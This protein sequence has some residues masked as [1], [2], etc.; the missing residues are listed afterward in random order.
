MRWQ[1]FGFQHSSDFLYSCATVT[2]VSSCKRDVISLLL[3]SLKFFAELYML[4]RLAFTNHLV[5]LVVISLIKFS[6][7]MS[8][9]DYIRVNLIGV[10]DW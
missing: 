9:N 5:T 1:N 6:F 4:A 7:K 2:L 3:I 10:L 8:S